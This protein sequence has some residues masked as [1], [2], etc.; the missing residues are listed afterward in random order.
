M[1]LTVRSTS[2]PFPFE[3]TLTLEPVQGG[4]RLKN[5]ITAGS[6]SGCTSF[7]FTVFPWLLRPMMR[8]RLRKELNLLKEVIERE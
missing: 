5:E 8:G 2:G 1:K 4:T 3:G 7:L 6:D